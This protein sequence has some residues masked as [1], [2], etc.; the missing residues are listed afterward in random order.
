M[1]SIEVVPAVGT[2][3][4]PSSQSRDDDEPALRSCA[5][6]DRVI[7]EYQS[8][9][10]I[11]D[12]APPDRQCTYWGRAAQ[13][14]Q[15]SLRFVPCQGL[16]GDYPD[17][18]K[19]RIVAFREKKADW[20]NKAAAQ[21]TPPQAAPDPTKMDMENLFNF[22]ETPND[23]PSSGSTAENDDPLTKSVKSLQDATDDFAKKIRQG[24][25]ANA[26]KGLIQD[27][28]GGDVPAPHTECPEHKFTFDWQPALAICRYG[29][30]GRVENT[31]ALNPDTVHQPIKSWWRKSQ[32]VV[33]AEACDAGPTAWSAING[34]KIEAAAIAKR[35]AEQQIADLDNRFKFEYDNADAKW[36]C[37][38]LK[39][40]K[41]QR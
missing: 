4:V 39:D 28:I 9:P 10:D 25:V 8:L 7:A 14:L 27:F 16:A 36:T 12:A 1:S 15:R 29:V 2:C 26:D 38:V 32:A 35:S 34:A 13:L 20:C 22:D 5:E 3:F 23:Q 41:L 21:A 11:S 37:I 31:R 40:K 18:L 24:Y 30:V 33:F 17:K 6:Y 19:R